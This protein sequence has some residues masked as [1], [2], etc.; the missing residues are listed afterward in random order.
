MCTWWY[1]ISVF[2]LSCVLK[3]IWNAKNVD[4]KI[5]KKLKHSTKIYQRY[6]T[7]NAKTLCTGSSP[8]LSPKHKGTRVPQHRPAPSLPPQLTKITRTGQ[9]SWEAKKI[10]AVSFAP[11][12]Q[13]RQDTNGKARNVPLREYYPPLP[14]MHQLWTVANFQ[15][16]TK[17]SLL[18]MVRSLGTVVTAQ[19]C[20]SYST[21]V[22]LGFCM[23]A[24]S[25]EIIVCSGSLNLG[26]RLKMKYNFEDWN[27]ISRCLFMSLLGMFQVSGVYGG[28]VYWEIRV[29]ML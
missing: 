9:N 26:T 2:V 19:W 11:L 4:Y 14:T 12:V 24:S 6:S 25:Q 21:A 18:I 1:A 20:Q 8:C 3:K 15:N 13:P 16:T 5:K 23:C 28:Q 29:T 7:Q 10:I 17:R 22:S 27:M